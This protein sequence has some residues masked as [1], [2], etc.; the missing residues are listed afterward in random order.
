MLSMGV[1]R[2]ELGVQTVFN[3]I[4]T[5]VD[6]GHTVEDVV[7][8]TRVLKDSGMKVCYHMMPGLPGSTFSRDLEAFQVIFN[9]PSFKPDM[10]KI[11]PCLVIKGTRIHDWWLNDRYEPYTTE[12]AAE[13]I[14][15]VK[16]MIP[17]W[18]R[19]MRIQRDIPAGL[20]MAGVKRSDLRQL[21]LQKLRSQSLSCRC[22]RCREGGHRTLNDNVMPDHEKI[23]VQKLE[24]ES[25][26]GTEFFISVEDP[27]NDVLIGY[28]R[29]RAPS[30]K[31]H[32]SEIYSD[33]STIVRELH[34]YGDLV[35]VGRRVAEAWQHKGYGAL[36][37]SEAE[38]VSLEELNRKK[39]LITSALGTKQYYKALGYDY[40]GP[41]VSKRLRN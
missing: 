40:D 25:S 28:L 23:Q 18:V 15:Q 8:A 27:H 4:Y 5:H 7:E 26:G 14:A 32:R 10:L 31:A 20:I 12:E 41:Y 17:P 30:E 22:I 38:R 19:V 9:D 16:K 29:L 34:V 35:P 33:A 21:A 3:D 1:T 2:V 24:Y 39:I 11:Y 36:L 37:L 13:L 6:R